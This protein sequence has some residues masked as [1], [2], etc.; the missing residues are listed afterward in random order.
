MA[1]KRLW[2]LCQANRAGYEISAALTDTLEVTDC[3]TVPELMTVINS[4]NFQNES[5]SPLPG[6]SLDESEIEAFI[7]NIL[8]AEG[9]PSPPGVAAQILE[10]Y[11]DE[12]VKIETMARVISADPVLAARLIGYCNSPI[13]ARTRNTTSLDQ[14]I[15]AVG[16]R[17]AKMIG[18]SFSLIQAAP[19]NEGRFDYQQFWNRSLATAIASRTLASR[20]NENCDTAFLLGL[21]LNI[22]Q[23]VLAHTFQEPYFEIVKRAEKCGVS[24]RSLE[25]KQW[26]CDHLKIG[27]KL[28]LMWKFS[29]EMAS[30]ILLADGPHSDGVHS[31]EQSGM[32]RVLGFA[33]RMA[34]IL[35]HEAIHPSRI[36]DIRTNARVSLGMDESL[37]DDLFN[38]SVSLWKEYA[39]LLSFDWSRAST[40]GQ[41]ES[42]ARHKMLEA[43]IEIQQENKKILEEN[44]SL[45][46]N[47]YEDTLT[48]LKNRRA[49]EKE[50]LAEHDRCRRSRSPFVML[51]LDIDFFKSVN[52][53]YGHT[54]GDQVL[55]EV[56]KTL[57]EHARKYDL[58]F[59]TGG[60]EF[61]IILADCDRASARVVA[62]RF[63]KSVESRRIDYRGNVLSVT[64][65]IGVASS[66]Y[67][68]LNL[69]DIYQEADRMLYQ[70]KSNGR[71]CCTHV[72]LGQD[73]APAP[74][75]ANGPSMVF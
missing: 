5:K 48:G 24:V 36:Q 45:Q 52:D 12:D 51:L 47:A 18:L 38:E 58:V 4:M 64:V 21:V 27:E 60:E 10:L 25:R 22:G 63:R 72:S 43:S 9:L 7:Q 40:I 56:A 26:G 69:D 31:G 28:L 68:H 19:A 39:K 42:R 71:N 11:A 20:L 75:A 3:V 13:L 62:E 37:F 57:V 67:P 54:A 16:L 61:V 70:S 59:R 15:V 35:F 23:M 30:E 33:E 53:T 32:G 44:Q 41:L 66:G 14:A 1:S 29:P 46:L 65:S 49:Y 73:M 2:G 34:E 8:Q 6:T 55:I 50:A 74:P 17:T